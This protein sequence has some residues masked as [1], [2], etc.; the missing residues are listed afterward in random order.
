MVVE[1]NGRAYINAYNDMKGEAR[2]SLNFHVNKIQIHSFVKQAE[3]AE[4]VVEETPP[5]VEDLPF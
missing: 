5:P 2:A 3:K 4:T 1:L